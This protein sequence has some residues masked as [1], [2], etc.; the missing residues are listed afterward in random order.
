MRHEPVNYLPHIDG[1]RSIAVLSVVFHHFSPEIVPGGYIGV[2]IFFVI[3]GYLIAGIIKREIE[4]NKFT[5]VGFYERRVRRIF[6]ALFGVLIFSIILGFLF[7][8]PSDFIITLRGL[9]GTLFFV[10]N[11]VFWRDFGGGY[12]G[13]TEDGLIPLVHTWSLSVEE[14]FYVFFPLFLFLLYKFKFNRLFIVSI[15]IIGFFISLFLSAYFIKEKSVAVFFLT[16]FR[17]WELLAGV[18]LVFNIFPEIKNKFLNEILSLAAFIALIYPCFF[19]SNLTIFPGLNAL[20]P[21]IGSAILIHLGKTN[22][23]YV[24]D[25]LKIKVMVFIGLISYSLYLWH[26]PILV[27]SKYFSQNLTILDNT[28]ILFTISIIISSFSYLYIE[29]PFRGK[30]GSEL[31]S[32]RNIFSLSFLLV[33]FLSIFSFYGILNKGMETRFS[34]KV[35]NFDKARKPDVKFIKCDGIPNSQNWCILGNKSKDPETIFFGDSHLLSWAHAIESIYVKKNESAILG[36]LSACPPFFNLIYSGSEFRKN[37]SCIEKNIEMENFIKKND[38]IKNVVLIGVWPSYFRGW[39]TLI[40]D[41]DGKGNFKNEKGAR[42]GLE[43]T[44]NKLNK[45]GKNVILVGPVPVYDENVPLSHANALIQNKPFKSTNYNQVIDYNSIFFDYV[46]KNKK[47]F[48]FINPLKWICKPNCLTTIDGK[49]LYWD[50]N[51][52]NEFGSLY[53]EQYLALNLDTVL[54]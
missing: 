11:L 20:L 45:F 38:K 40:V 23:S 39:H 6:P 31:I 27:F 17:I 42:L 25:F 47:D 18:V 22:H 52:L 54:N 12:F 4:E 15:L 13:A 2:D 16:P 10:S 43:Q 1:L 7:L 35:V 24:K 36:V 34:E 37:N 29:Q 14:Q 51:H 53:L 49:S 30:K 46:E 28:F 5:F 41:I 33:L 3:S 50:N 9:I 8:L 21:V 48:N 44:I 26:W 19:Y 32:R